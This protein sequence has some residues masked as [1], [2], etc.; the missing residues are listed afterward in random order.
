LEAAACGLPVIAWA[1]GGA[2]ET[3]EEGRTGI[4]F[5]E[6]AIGALREAIHRFERATF[7]TDEIR[8][9]A[10][11]FGRERFKQEMRDW[12]QSR[13]EARKA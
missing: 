10:L 11:R 2:L 3:V 6:P 13:A 7:R 5:R 1:R 4:F 9:R 12:I 8:R